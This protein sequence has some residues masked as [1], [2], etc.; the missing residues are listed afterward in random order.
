MFIHSTHPHSFFFL[1]VTHTIY[2]LHLISF[3][4]YTSSPL[5]LSLNLHLPSRNLLVSSPPTS[6]TFTFLLSYP[7]LHHISFSTL[8]L[9]F[10]IYL[11]Y[12]LITSFFYLLLL[13]PS[14]ISSHKLS[15]ILTIFTFPPPGQSQLPSQS[16]RRGSFPFRL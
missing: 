16:S 7:H 14:F 3:Y 5:I 15:P 8:S 10:S 2:T 11:P 9:F 4:L 13:S 1:L 6:P 12:P